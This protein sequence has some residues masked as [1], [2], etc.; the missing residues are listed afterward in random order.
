[1]DGARDQHERSTA[2]ADTNRDP[3]GDSNGDADPN[4][5]PDPDTDGD[6]DTDD[7]STRDGVR[8]AD[9]GRLRRRLRQQLQ[10]GSGDVVRLHRRTDRDR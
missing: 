6:P 3:N 1:V 4:G 8:S 9:A 5:D 7:T 2:D 10:H